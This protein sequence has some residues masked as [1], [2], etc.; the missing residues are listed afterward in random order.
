MDLLSTTLVSWMTIQGLMILRLWKTSC[1]ILRL[2]LI[3]SKRQMIQTA[4]HQDEPVGLAARRGAE[5][6]RRRRERE[7]LLTPWVLHTLLLLLVVRMRTR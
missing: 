2:V 1:L 6:P 5:F 4:S 7:L 3:Q